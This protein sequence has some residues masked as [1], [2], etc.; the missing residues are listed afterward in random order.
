MAVSTALPAISTMMADSLT[1]GD[2]D[3]A[4]DV[5]HGALDLYDARGRFLTRID[6]TGGRHVLTLDLRRLLPHLLAYP[7]AAVILRHRHPSGIAAPSR[8][9]IATTRALTTLLH[10]LGIRLHDHLIEGG[11]DQ[12]SFRA[13]GLI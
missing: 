1:D 11:R 2:H 8:A 10:L 9:D 5:E 4:R 12:F 13:E 7:C 6:L 3:E